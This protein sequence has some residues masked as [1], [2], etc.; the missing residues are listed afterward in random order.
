MYFHWF[1]K[2]HNR[3]LYKKIRRSLIFNHFSSSFL[4]GEWKISPTQQTSSENPI[5]KLIIIQNHHPISTKM[6]INN[7][8]L[9][10]I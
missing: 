4:E 5:V 2:K 3:Y 10:N 9:Q 1:I 7:S 6:M 8:F